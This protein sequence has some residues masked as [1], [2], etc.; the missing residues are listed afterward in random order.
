MNSATG[1]PRLAL[2]A[3][4][5]SLLLVGIA[6]L[7]LAGPV[8]AI[9]YGTP[10]PTMAVPTS[11]AAAA[12]S[13]VALGVR[14]TSALGSFLTGSNGFTLYTL[15]SDPANGSVCTGGC[16][17][18]WP[19]LTVAAAGRTSATSGASATFGSFTRTDT[20]VH[21]V[22]LNGRALYYFKNDHA[23]GDTN[24][25]GIAALGGVWHVARV[26]F[27]ARQASSAPTLPATSTAGPTEG[28]SP[29][30]SLPTVLAM[31]AVAVVV[32]LAVTRRLARTVR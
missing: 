1:A 8:G 25:E 18:F 29:G 12:P 20:G 3:I 22:T 10:P 13:S 15:S 4:V 6:S 16:L 19:P 14:S 27:A 23:A 9:S 7:T 26:T 30:R 31:L 32:G 28:R 24:G 17:S 2:P 21:Q 5:A 11:T